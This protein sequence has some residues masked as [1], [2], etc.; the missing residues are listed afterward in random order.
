MRT[1]INMGKEHD[2]I[3]PDCHRIDIFFYT[4]PGQLLYHP[5]HSR[6]TN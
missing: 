4:L 2:D 1:A 3:N 5:L 6:N